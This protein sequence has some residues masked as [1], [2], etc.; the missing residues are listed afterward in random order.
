[1]TALRF[2]LMAQ[3][4][5]SPDVLPTDVPRGRTRMSRTILALGLAALVFAA[6]SGVSRAA[7]LAPLPAG[8][9]RNDFTPVWCHWHCHHWH[10]WC[11]WHRC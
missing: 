3:L 9:A 4:D 8:V 6:F 7:P 2:D 11:H 10:H 1:M 5:R